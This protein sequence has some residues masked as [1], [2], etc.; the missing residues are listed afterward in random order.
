MGDRTDEIVNI[1]KTHARQMAGGKFF[2]TSNV[3]DRTYIICTLSDDYY[4]GMK[5]GDHRMDLLYDRSN[6]TVRM[7]VWDLS[8]GFSTPTFELQEPENIGTE[9]D[10]LLAYMRANTQTHYV[11]VWDRKPKRTK[12]RLFWRR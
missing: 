5:L 3:N 10:G 1:F 2:K 9:M 11:R 12:R 6:G 8:H 7:S 4:Y